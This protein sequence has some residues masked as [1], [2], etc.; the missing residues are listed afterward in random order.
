MQGPRG[1]L[2]V[3]ARVVAK[4][5]TADRVADRVVAKALGAVPIEEL[6]QAMMRAKAVSPAPSYPPHTG[7][8]QRCA[9]PSSLPPP[10]HTHPRREVPR[11]RFIL[12]LAPS[13]PPPVPPLPRPCPAQQFGPVLAGPVFPGG[14]PPIRTLAPEVR[15]C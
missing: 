5:C 2:T 7:Q 1:G 6:R 14:V 12:R 10:P 4:G 15:P 8:G 11:P 13:C 3:L 9:A